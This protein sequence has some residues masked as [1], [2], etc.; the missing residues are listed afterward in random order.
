MVKLLVVGI[1]GATW[2]VVDPLIA[3]GEL[4]QL[5]R[6]RDIGAS[7]TMQA[8]RYMLNSALLW[9]SINSGKLPEKHGIEFFGATAT[10]VRCKRTWD[11]LEEHGWRVGVC[12]EL[13]TWPPRQINGFLVPDLFA[14]GPET[15]P[16]ELR[17]LQEIALGQKNGEATK[18][19]IP[20]AALRQLVRYGVRPKTTAASAAFLARRKLRAHEPFLSWFWR[21]ALLQPRLY[22]DVAAQLTKGLQLDYLSFHFHTTDTLSHRYWRYW[23]PTAFEDVDQEEVERYSDVIPA[24]YREADRTLGRLLS[25]AGPETTIVV[26]SDHG[27]KP[28]PYGQNYQ[29]TLKLE[30]LMRLLDLTTGDTV[31]ARLGPE[32]VF[33]LKDSSRKGAVA[34]LLSSVR[35]DSIDEPLFDVREG[36]GFVSFVLADRGRDLVGCSFTAS[37]GTFVFDDLF[38]DRGFVDS[39]TH[40]PDGIIIMAGNGV[41]RGQSLEP[42][43][44]LDVSPTLLTLAGIPVPRDMDGRVL[45][46]ALTE[47]FLSRHPI[48]YCDSYESG[49]RLAPDGAIESEESDVVLER[50]KALGYL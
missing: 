50:L 41:R 37:F 13:V 38:E 15:Y 29:Y 25:L 42:V 36:D 27:F 9:T 2:S 39:G 46:E 43:S 35:I 47:E 10:D 28:I 3:R 19:R 32:H 16:A 24:A 5:K 26:V 4:P 40:H 1:D 20:G 23:D 33:Y 34:N 8:F 14:L 44:P 12:G 45:S 22:T 31:P 18:Q 48:T 21:K 11:L 49:D 17:F 7:G 6:L 30:Y